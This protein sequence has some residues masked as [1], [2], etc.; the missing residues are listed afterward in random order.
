MCTADET[1]FTHPLSVYFLYIMS[2]YKFPD[3][4]R[5]RAVVQCQ[6]SSQHEEQ[7]PSILQ[8]S[9]L[10]LMYHTSTTPAAE[11]TTPAVSTGGQQQVHYLVLLL[12]PELCHTSVNQTHL[13]Q[14]LLHHQLVCLPRIEEN[15]LPG[16][17]DDAS[18]CYL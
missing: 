18:V 12:P 9:L 11:S 4:Q 2:N 17:A 16:S 5:G 14:P 1:S 8:T 15:P 6:P 7:Q 3:V 10:V 13:V